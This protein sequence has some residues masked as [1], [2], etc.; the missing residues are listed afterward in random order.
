MADDAILSKARDAVYGDRGRDYG[1]PMDNHTRTADLWSAWLRNRFRLAWNFAITAEDV[2]ALNR[3]Q[4]EARLVQ[5]P[6]HIDSLVDLAGYAENQAL[7]VAERQ[8][9]DHG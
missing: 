3:L 6:G 7:I 2:C 9:H 8:A 1:T 5:T 4:K